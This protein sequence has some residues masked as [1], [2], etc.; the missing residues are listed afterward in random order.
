[1]VRQS[2]KKIEDD[3]PELCTEMKNVDSEKD[4]RTGE[5]KSVCIQGRN[6]YSR[7]AIKQDFAM[8]IKE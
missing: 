5:V 8:G 2:R 7:M 1:M 4:K 6:N 3:I